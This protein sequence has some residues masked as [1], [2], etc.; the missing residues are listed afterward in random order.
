MGSDGLEPKRKLDRKLLKMRESLRVRA[1]P[2]I[3]QKTL[4]GWGTVSSPV[5]RRSRWTTVIS[6]PAGLRKC[7]MAPLAGCAKALLAG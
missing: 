7:A 5:G 1:L 4:D 3:E 6:F 2:P